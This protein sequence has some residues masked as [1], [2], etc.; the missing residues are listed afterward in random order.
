MRNVI[1]NHISSIGCCSPL[2]QTNPMLDLTTMLENMNFVF[3]TCFSTFSTPV[4]WC[5]DFYSRIVD[6]PTFSTPAFQ[7]PRGLSEPCRCSLV[8][9]DEGSRHYWPHCHIT[10]RH[11]YGQYCLLP[12][13]AIAG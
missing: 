13:P 4:F 7:S 3:H 12:T 11:Y 2:G 1:L 10:A 8:A 9:A 5:H 6:A